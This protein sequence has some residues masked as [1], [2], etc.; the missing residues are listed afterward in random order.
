MKTTGVPAATLS[1]PKRLSLLFVLSFIGLVFGACLLE[2]TVRL[3]FPTTDF[4][5]QWDS[6][7]GL[8]LIPGMRGRSVKP[9]VFDVRVDV[10][11]AGFRDREHSIEKPAGIRRIALLGDSFVEAIQV[12]FE[13]SITAQ[14][15]DRLKTAGRET[16]LL[17]FAVSGTGTARHYLALQEYAAA[18]KPDV[19]LLFFFAGN[20]ISD[21]SR[22][23]SGRSYVP[24]PQTNSDGV[25]IRSENG[26]PAFTPF[27]DD[28]SVLTPI[29]ELLKNRWKSYRFLRETID[30]S[31]AVNRLLHSFNSTNASQE[32]VS[33]PVLENLGLYEVYRIEQK[34]VWAEAWRVSEELILAVQDFAQ[35]HGAKL[36]VVLIPA[37][38]EVYP[39]LWDAI[40]ASTPG[41]REVALDPEQ[42]SK[43]FTRF[44]TDHGVAV[45][46][47]LPEF[48]QR[49]TGSS[50]LYIESDGHWTA[51]GH[52]LAADLIAPRVSAML[53]SDGVSTTKVHT[54]AQ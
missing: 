43:R 15:E 33:A 42:P 37:S 49:A 36:G 21:N 22:R 5:W 30:N 7:I 2:V 3:F 35:T 50:S 46:N 20:D 47:L 48:R 31:P 10:N 12:P 25:L 44:L 1:L 51:E 6:R 14:L 29:T 13:D 26:E 19:V 11:S 18:Y 32:S 4:L 54:P 38:W 16:E 40:L 53:A 45:L 23:L 24:Y 41:M 28:S 8:T 9:G 27:S 34:P 17:N 52:R 39:H